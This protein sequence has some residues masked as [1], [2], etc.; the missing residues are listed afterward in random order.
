M[1]T[2][3]TMSQVLKTYNLMHIATIDANGSPCVRG[4]DFALS[5]KENVLY[6]V[7]QKDSRKVAQIAGNNNVA[8]AIDKDCPEF[9][10]LAELKYI[11]GTGT[12]TLIDSPDEM[13]KAFGLL[14][15]KFPFLADMPGDPADFAG[16]K[17]ELKNVLVTDNAI[18]FGNTE[19]ISF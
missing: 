14:I 17:V 13:Q 12:A 2:K 9:K 7:T 3:E 1:S 16:I 8:F 5:D 4:V 18:H 11:K 15:K 10:D 19:E 6:F